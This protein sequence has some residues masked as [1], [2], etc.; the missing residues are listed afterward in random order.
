MS[1]LN[2]MDREVEVVSGLV[3]KVIDESPTND[4]LFNNCQLANTEYGNQ[5]R[6]I[7]IKTDLTY[8]EP[9]TKRYIIAVGCPTVYVM[10]MNNRVS[11]VRKHSSAFIEPSFAK[12]LGEDVVKRD[13]SLHES[14]VSLYNREPSQF[15]LYQ[16][17][18]KGI[19]IIEYYTIRT[20]Q[21]DAFT[22]NSV[23]DNLCA[24][25]YNSS[26]NIETLS[27]RE[28][29]TLKNK[30]VTHTGGVIKMRN[31]TFI[32]LL[33][34]QEHGIAYY[35]DVNLMFSTM[36]MDSK[37]VHPL[38][39]KARSTGHKYV[40]NTLLIKINDLYN[41]GTNGYWIKIGKRV[42]KIVPSKDPSLPNGGSI[43]LITTNGVERVTKTNSLE[44]L[45][46]LGIYTSKELAQ[47]D[48]VGREDSRMLEE[49]AKQQRYNM[50]LDRLDKEK[51]LLDLKHKVFKERVEME[52]ALITLKNEM[53]Y[54]K[55]LY[56]L[57]YLQVERLVKLSNLKISASM[58][59]YKSV[60]DMML[61]K[62]KAETELELLNSRRT[63]EGLK[64]TTDIASKVLDV[65]NKIFSLL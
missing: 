34:L 4:F 42:E 35:S 41:Q 25:Y 32:P 39:K 49:I 57:E 19:Y 18:R 50:E 60:R 64:S 21:T 26:D 9:D 8:G 27:D 16:E 56:D 28:L 40:N 52:H 44:G 24:D 29:E 33:K 46:D 11:V 38:S 6:S 15:D 37:T 48:G 30:V 59:R 22:G 2:I 31:I 65:G 51:E 17:A 53:D 1:S 63:Y 62:Y 55:R 23:N 13:K 10:D 47:T 12:A 7:P 36:G 43:Q 3:S 14:Y 20:K 5:V 54:D 61:Y 58:D 45:A